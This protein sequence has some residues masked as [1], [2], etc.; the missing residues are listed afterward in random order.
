MPDRTHPDAERERKIA[1]MR[2]VYR[3]ALECSDARAADP[4]FVASRQ[5]LGAVLA[6]L[7]ALPEGT[8]S[9]SASGPDAA[10]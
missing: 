1:A 7:G 8:T 2:A 9:G 6:M 10:S 4:L 5:S 3:A